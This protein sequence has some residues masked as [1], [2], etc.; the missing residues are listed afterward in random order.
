MLAEEEYRVAEKKLAELTEVRE[1]ES[2][3]EVEDSTW[4]DDVG[5]KVLFQVDI[6]S[7]VFANAVTMESICNVRVMI[8]ICT[9]LEKNIRS[10]KVSNIPKPGIGSFLKN[11]H[12]GKDISEVV[13]DVEAVSATFTSSV[14]FKRKVECLSDAPLKAGMIKVPL[15]WNRR[16]L[17]N[18]KVCVTV[19]VSIPL[20]SLMMNP[21]SS[22]SPSDFQ[23]YVNVLGFVASSESTVCGSYSSRLGCRC[24]RLYLARQLACSCALGRTA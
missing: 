14:H 17:Y 4:E 15:R 19:T 16:I 8:Q 20:T 18:C 13:N 23:S 12:S 1:A 7:G 11:Q 6:G 24:S 3:G 2:A 5:Q 10:K 21:T 9:G 22:S